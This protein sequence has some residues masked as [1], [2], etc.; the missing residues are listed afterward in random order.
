MKR[1]MIVLG[2]LVLS[3]LACKKI[4][5]KQDEPLPVNRLKSISSTSATF[6]ENPFDSIGMAHNKTLEACWNHLQQSGDT[7][8]AGKRKFLVAYFKKTYGR[9]LNKTIAACAGMENKSF[10]EILNQFPMSESGR[11]LLREIINSGKLLTDEN[12]LPEYQLA[13]NKI[14]VDSQSAGLVKRESDAI[15]QVAAIARYSS[16]FWYQKVTDFSPPGPQGKWYTWFLNLTADNM[17]A[18]VGIFGGD[19]MGEA[20]YF[21]DM[22]TY[23]VH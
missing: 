11:E 23:Y 8:R 16:R 21:S 9:D 4:A 7:S 5:E 22:V 20:S 12:S 10:E 15:L 17:G 14:E 19:I 1:N 18:V 2:L 6:F 3:V 13:I